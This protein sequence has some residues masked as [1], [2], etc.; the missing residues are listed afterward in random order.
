MTSFLRLSRGNQSAIAD[1]TINEGRKKMKKHLKKTL[2][3]LLACVI[4]MLLLTS[5][6]SGKAGPSESDGK[7]LESDKGKRP[8]I[9]L[10]MS[11]QTQARQLKDVEYLKKSLDEL[12]YDVTVQYAEMDATKQVAQIETFIS[13]GVDG[14]II[15]AWDAESLSTVVDNAAKNNIPVL[16]YD[17]LIS[18]TEHISYYV[19]D[20]L[21]DC[22]KL[23]GNYIVKALGLE[24]GQKGPFTLELFSGDPADSNAPHFYNG[25]YDV[26]KPY[27]EEGVL[28]VLS[29]QT[30]ISENAT[31]NWDGLKAQE[32]M[33]TI[34]STFYNSDD[35]I[36]DAVMCNNDALALGVLAS[37][38]NAGYTK[39]S[40]IKPLPV[41]T[42]MDC[43]IANIKAIKAGEISMTV[44]KDNRLIAAKA[45]EV[46][47]DI[48][49]GRTPTAGDAVEAVFNNG[50][51]DVQAFLI[52]PI[53]IDVNNY[54]EILFDS[55]YYSED[56]LD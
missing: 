12:G 55:G 25:A 46:M 34:L 13:E 49:N 52:P 27:I 24:D 40:A 10:S 47:V 56:M 54:Q 39:D 4:A 3:L 48:I 8:V 43:D 36:I 32:R 26:L 9:G 20:N 42:G 6:D 30:N 2:C 1:L 44:F 28:K 23:Q 17:M 37:L 41:I 11:T 22:G 35:V 33:D 21:Y 14:I 31:L 18:N 53:A 38:K 5:C 16:A 50:V 19:T 51:R 29:G 45:A 7:T 15:S